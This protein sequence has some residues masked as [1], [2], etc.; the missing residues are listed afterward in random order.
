MALVGTNSFALLQDDVEDAGENSVNTEAL[1]TEKKPASAPAK[2]TKP[3]AKDEKATQKRGSGSARGR[4]KGRGNNDRADFEQGPPMKGQREHRNPRHSDRRD[5]PSGGMRSA[6]KREHDRKSGTGRGREVSKRGAG[7]K[8]VFGNDKT[9]AR[10]AEQ[11][12]NAALQSG[13]DEETAVK[14]AQL[15]PA[16]DE[17]D[18][19]NAESVETDEEAGTKVPDEDKDITI[20]EFEKM[21]LEASRADDD[22]FA[23][24]KPRRLINDGDSLG[25][26]LKKD[27]NQSAQPQ[28]PKRSPKL[29]KSPAEVKNT[30]TAEFF[31]SQNSKPSGRRND[32]D[33]RRGNDGNRGSYSGRSRQAPAPRVDDVSAFPSL[34]G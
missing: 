27:E 28:T 4:G 3:A 19:A 13:A 21:K 26:A 14:A 31:A 23:A 16:L 5:H 10:A 1:A 22:I 8:Y 25:E 33:N 18:G 29:K 15:E 6:G 34:G 2:D 7:G 24:P 30:A 32:R 20:E 12:A 11:S 9:D 17:A